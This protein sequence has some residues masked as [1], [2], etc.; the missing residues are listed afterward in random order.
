MTKTDNC[1]EAELLEGSGFLANSHFLL[2]FSFEVFLK[3]KQLDIFDFTQIPNLIEMYCVGNCSHSGD[4]EAVV[5]SS[6]MLS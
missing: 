4:Y 1:F 3:F 2:F 6:T 5:V